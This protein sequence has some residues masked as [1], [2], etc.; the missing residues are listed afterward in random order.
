MAEVRQCQHG[1][2]APVEVIKNLLPSQAKPERHQCAVCAYAE[3][4]KCGLARGRQNNNA[5]TDAEA[6]RLKG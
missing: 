1:S 2:A 3:G 5:S 6:D 4:Y